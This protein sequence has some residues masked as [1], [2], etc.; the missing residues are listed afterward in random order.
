LAA[1]EINCFLPAPAALKGNTRTQV[2]IPPTEAFEKW[3]EVPF[4]P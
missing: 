2:R 1:V 4:I 3:I